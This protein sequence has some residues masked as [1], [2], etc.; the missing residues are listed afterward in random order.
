MKFKITR[1]TIIAVF[2]IYILLF[3]FCAFFYQDNNL[4]K[5]EDNVV[6]FDNGWTM[7]GEPVKLPI[8]TDE[9]FAIEN[10]MPL[11]YNNNYYMIIKARYDEIVVEVDGR[12]IFQSLS[13]DLN[14]WD[15]NA[16][17][18]EVN[19]PLKGEYSGKPLKITAKLH[20]SIYGGSLSE[21]IVSNGE[22]YL[23]Y[24]IK[25][26]LF[27]LFLIVVFI[28]SG[29]I[30][31]A[32]ALYCI[33]KKIKL[34]RQFTFEILLYAGL[35]SNMTAVWCLCNTRIPALLSGNMV[36]YS[37]IGYISFMLMPLTFAA[38]IYSIDDKQNI[39]LRSLVY[40]SMLVISVELLLVP[41]GVF[42]YA[43]TTMTSHIM[44]V[45]CI[46]AAIY[47]ARRLV[48]GEGKVK[49]EKR[50]IALGSATFVI[51]CSISLFIYISNRETGFVQY[52]LIAML[53]Y[54][55]T[56]VILI[57]NRIGLNAEEAA[58]YEVTQVFAYT[59]ELTQLGNRRYFWNMLEEREK[60][61]IS[62]DITIIYMDVNRLKYYNDTMGHE[63]GDELLKG[64]AEC[65]TRVFKD[66][67]CS[68]MGG[69]EY[70]VCLSATE[71]E[72]DK[73]I[74]KF[75]KV[76]AEF[77]GEFVDGISVA[78]GVAAKR[79]Y[80]DASLSDLTK[81]ADDKMYSDKKEYYEKNK[82]ERRRG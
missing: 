34:R 31:E 50:I 1:N 32:M 52:F 35:F 37:I 62:P 47:V 80:P 4:T 28:T 22:A 67:I 71:A 12:V 55:I 16:G 3:V 74:K 29:L 60:K 38:M 7:D 19:V 64:T 41:A 79:D 65:I 70:A 78:V 75:C 26:N 40:G 57:L 10:T 45:L 44:D 73:L 17:N 69:D 27:V 77:K 43:Q 9:E 14:N 59:D 66:S 13:S 18:K 5:I 46:F 56:I 54:I 76:A 2:I 53:I 58:D 61:G 30:E 20:H 39:V 72:T 82:I 6:V 48:F 23:L 42:D 33:F 11:V 68:R 51:V 24:V 25:E 8:K 63:A 49:G 21:I 81:F 15:T 36:T